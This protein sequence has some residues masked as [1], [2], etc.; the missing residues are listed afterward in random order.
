MSRNK[1]MLWMG[2]FFLLALNSPVLWRIVNPSQTFIYNGTAMTYVLGACLL[3]IIY[4][5]TK[6]DMEKQSNIKKVLVL[7]LIGIVLSI[8]LQGALAL[9]EV[10][11]FNQS[12]GSQNTENIKGII[13]ASPL[14]FIAVAIGGPI[15]EECVFR[16]GLI[17]WL[18]QW[19]PLWLSVLISSL[20][21]AFMH[22]DG[23][24]LVYGGM[25]LLFFWLYHSTG[26]IW[27]NIIAHAGM[28]TVV[29]LMQ[30]N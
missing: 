17:C 2:F 7:G 14:F 8:L 12:L 4:K 15:M 1:S 25:G 24:Y 10:T 13:Q 28:N 21:F 30:L 11:L 20:A 22:G 23:H 5:R 18:E 19:L 16:F 26:S 9:V 3:L 29:L 6:K 27:T